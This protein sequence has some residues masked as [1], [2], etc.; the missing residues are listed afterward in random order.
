M[1]QQSDPF[2]DLVPEKKAPS[3]RREARA[4]DKR[5]RSRAGRRGRGPAYRPKPRRSYGRWIGGL[6]ALAL[7]G[8]LVAIALTLYL[9]PI[10]SFLAGEP[11]GPQDYPGPG[12]GE[13]IFTVHDG[14]YGSDIAT[15]LQ[16]DDVIGSSE[17]FYKLLLKQSPEPVFIPG[18]YEMRAQMSA[19][20]ALK[21]LMD[22]DTRMENTF[23]IPE[24]TVVR[25]ALE[26]IADGTKIPLEELQ[27][28]ADDYESFDLPE[29]AI[30]LEGFLF[31]ATYNLEP[32]LDAHSVLQ[33]LVDRMDQ[34]LDQAGVEEKDRFRVVT[35]ASLVQ[36]EAGGGPGD[37]AKVARVFQNRLDQGWKLQSDATVTY[38]RTTDIDRT[39]TSD[40]ER[41]DADNPYNTYAHE[42]LPIGP[43]GNPGDVAIEAV[44]H[45]ADGPWMFFVTWNLQTGET[46]FST[47]VEEHDAAV[48]KWREWM[49]ENPEY[50]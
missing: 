8:G 45:P 7:F 29:E 47:T 18:A 28:A 21:A 14:D 3:S 43:I 4:A 16:S 46:I 32:D 50:D 25:V 9:E 20:Q 12:T 5:S 42:G 40:A 11:P 30:N 13:V 19:S 15:N 24:G 33:V 6:L 49:R 48:E 10:K 41:E 37:A 31:P 23:V 22:P 38:Y 1:S 44:L 17:V 34:A 2:A 36:R 35:F 39:E 27:A 26:L